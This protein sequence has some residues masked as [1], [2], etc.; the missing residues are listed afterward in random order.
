MPTVKA[1]DGTEIFFHDWGSGPPVVLIH[2]WPLN[3]DMWEHQS[4]HLA[5]N[6]FRVIAYDRRGFGR[7][8]KPWSGH[9]Y[10]TFADDL[11]ALLERLDLREVTLVAHSMGGGD[12]VRYLSRHGA[13]RV[14]G[15]VLVAATTPFLLRTADN[16]DGVK[17]AVYDDMVTAL[18]HDRPGFM[19]A[20][21]PTF[22]GSGVASGAVSPELMGWAVGLALQ[23]C[24]IGLADMVR[25]FSETDFRPELAELTVP[26]LIVHGDA[27]SNVP[28]DLCGRRAARLV[29]GSRLEVYEGAPHGLMITHRDRLNADLLAFAS[30]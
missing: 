5:N 15:L 12:A 1:K 29:P 10:D 17:Q 8:G 16:P 13:S 28:V 21:A 18:A 2:G 24:P 20:S 27:D 22:F 11:A 9:D 14:A 4:L 23:A 6:G 30:G 3:A 19:A 25:A 7:S 26:T